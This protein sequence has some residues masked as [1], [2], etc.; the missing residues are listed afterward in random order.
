MSTTMRPRTVIII[1]ARYGSQRLP[2][3]MLAEIAG[4]PMIQHVVERAR[5]CTLADEVLVA[6]DDERIAARVRDAGATSVMTP[7]ELASGSDRV[8][9][10]ARDLRTADI[11]VNL[12]GDEPMIDPAMIDEAIRPLH[13]DPTLRV[14]T[15]VRAVSTQAELLNPAL[16]K[17]VLDREHN[18]IYFSRA[19][20]PYLR[21]VPQE[22]WLEHHTYYRHIGIY[23]FRRACL[24]RFASFPQTPLERAEKL[25]QLRLLENAERIRAV[26]TTYDSTGV[27]TASDL[28]RVRAQAGARHA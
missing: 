15:L 16:P 24:L 5:R 9:W 17:V 23:V 14:S 6:T 8:A 21:D 11:V 22:H 28:E 1:P 3:K 2:G 27:D 12:Q 25:E 4:R 18:C 7:A 10:V 26:I 20:V 19:P 13:E